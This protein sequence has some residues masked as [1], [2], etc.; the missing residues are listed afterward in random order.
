MSTDNPGGFVKIDA[1]IVLLGCTARGRIDSM[2]R[3]IE[4]IENQ[5]VCFKQKI[6]TVDEL[7]GSKLSDAWINTY[8]GRG[9]EISINPNKG[10]VNNLSNGLKLVKEDWI[11]YVED[12]VIIHRFPNKY[13][14]ARIAN[15]EYQGRYPGIISY[16]YVGYQFKRI[17]YERLQ[18]SVSNP[19]QFIKIDDF[20]FWARDDSM[21][22]GYHVEF[23]VTF[24]RTNLI[25][26]C[27]MCAKRN[28]KKQFI[29]S[30]MTGAW[31]KLGLNKKYF[32]GT[33]LNYDDNII[34]DIR[35]VQPKAY[36]EMIRTK[37][38]S[39]WVTQNLATTPGNK[40]F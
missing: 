6:I 34:S 30:A 33:L 11:F 7:G 9:W 18:E 39:L 14:F 10:M 29:E 16:T 8:K 24:F 38:R 27:V 12:D 26:Q 40:K 35:M 23:P 3:L 5:P 21:N 28:F 22:Y 31:F 2:A 36:E 15:T 17:T 1:S 37:G 25:K 19:T 13:Q 32:K 4:S 20:L